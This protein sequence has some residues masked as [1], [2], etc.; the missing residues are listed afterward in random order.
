MNEEEAGRIIGEIV[1]FCADGKWNQLLAFM[2]ERGYSET[3]VDKAC[4]VFGKKIGHDLV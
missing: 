1:A 3:E 4:E 2:E